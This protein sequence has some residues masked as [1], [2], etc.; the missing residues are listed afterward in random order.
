MKN[1]NEEKRE[2]SISP[3]AEKYNKQLRS[4]DNN[5][6]RK[7]SKYE[8]EFLRSRKSNNLGNKIKESKIIINARDWQQQKECTQQPK[9]EMSL[10]N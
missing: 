5:D 8:K 2:K 10:W 4:N 6:K 9:T 3:F 7:K 1:C